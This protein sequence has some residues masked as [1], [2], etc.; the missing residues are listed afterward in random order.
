MK[1]QS[2]HPRKI[3]IQKAPELDREQ[4]KGRTIIAL[5]RLGEQRFS[6]EPGGYSLDNWAKGLNILLDDFEEKMGK[7]LLTSQYLARRRELNGLLSN[8]VSTSSI[9][10][11]IS[12]VRQKIADIDAKIEAEKAQ[13]TSRIAEIKGEQVRSS[14]ELARERERVA[15]L[16]AERSSGSFFSRLIGG[17]QKSLKDS[18]S[19]VEEFESRLGVLNTEMLEQQ[20]LLKSVERGSPES[21][22]AEEWN[23]SK[24]LQIR[25]EALESERLENVQL[26]KVREGV[27]TSIADAI[28]K[29]SS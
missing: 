23:A 29:M 4:L 18:N 1:N 20:K 17:G 8:P 3:R 15:N 12:E 24:S 28:T 22:L 14:A 26:V 2:F 9:D 25:L 21:P 7:G 5:K 11:D 13:V 6:D 10:G 19:R 27:T 16:A